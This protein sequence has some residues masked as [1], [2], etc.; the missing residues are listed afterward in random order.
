MWQA[1]LTTVSVLVCWSGTSAR[2]QLAVRSHSTPPTPKCQTMMD[3]YCNGKALTSCIAVIRTAHGEVPLVP[4]LDTDKELGQHA[5]RCY[6]G[7]ALNPN[8]TAYN[9]TAPRSGLYCTAHGLLAVLDECM[10]TPPPPPAPPTRL[11]MLTEA[12]EKLGAVC[13]DGS[14]PA[15]Y[16]R[17]GDPTKWHVHFEGGGWCYHDPPGL[18]EDNQ[19]FYRAYGP[20]IESNTP[21]HYLGSSAMLPSNYSTHPPRPFK[22][23]LGSDPRSNPGMHNWSF[24]FVH[25]CDGASFTGDLDAPVMVHGKPL[26]YRGRRIRDAAIQYLLSPAGGGMLTSAT[27]VAVS[28]TSAGMFS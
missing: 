10:P 5:W 13:L 14:A 27:D 17:K 25:Y 8:R 23:F 22:N 18:Q 9:T 4:L 11:I 15:I 19:C 1:V 20:S 6:S 24:A 12:A 26:Y 16:V 3:D 2:P 7:S 28:G 21:P